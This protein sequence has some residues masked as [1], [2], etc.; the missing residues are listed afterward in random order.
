[1]NKF[2]YTI[3]IIMTIAISSFGQIQNINFEDTTYKQSIIIDKISNPNNIWQVG[4]PQK[5]KFTSAYSIPNAILT[6]TLNYYPCND[7][8]SFILTHNIQ[9]N[10]YGSNYWGS[11]FNGSYYVNSD[12]LNDIG[13]IEVSSNKN[14]TWINLLTSTSFQIYNKP[15]LTGNSNGWQHFSIYIENYPLQAW[16]GDT[17]YL[18]FTFA[19]DGIQTNK[20]GLMFDD[21]QI[22]DIGEGIEEF[23]YGLINSKAFPNPVNDNL[24]IEFENTTN[25]SFDV[26]LID[27]TGKAVKTISDFKQ[28]SV[29]IN[30]K[31]LS[32]GIYYY[33]LINR[34]DKKNA[35]GKFIKQ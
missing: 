24:I 8:S 30:I 33:K 29:S 4:K 20:D 7:T 2:L 16:W 35:F 22:I 12:T 1:M 3:A 11:F 34:M 26:I 23:G 13:S 32:S 28:S 19:S 17:I 31:E 25:S 21:I 10:G 27:N 14:H 9:I 18:R 15:T 6:D 5:A